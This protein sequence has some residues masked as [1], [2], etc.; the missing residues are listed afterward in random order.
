MA[1]LWVIVGEEEKE[2]GCGYGCSRRA[3]AEAFVS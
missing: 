1:V 3:G 2:F